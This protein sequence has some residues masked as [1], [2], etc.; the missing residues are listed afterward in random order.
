MAGHREISAS[1]TDLGTSGSRGTAV[2]ADVVN[3]AIAGIGFIHAAGRL[4]V[5]MR[6]S[7]ENEHRYEAK[8]N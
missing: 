1:P 7:A 4:F 2:I 6:F 8:W 5:R 3:Y